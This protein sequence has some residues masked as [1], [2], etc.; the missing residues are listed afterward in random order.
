M[1]RT[2]LAAVAAATML[3]VPVA[4]SAHVPGAGRSNA[5]V[6][7]P[8]VAKNTE[9]LTTVPLGAAIS[10]E[11]AHT[12]SY[13]YVSLANGVA[14][15]DTSNPEAPVIKDFLPQ[16]EFENEAMTYGERPVPA[17]AAHPDGLSRFVL[18]GNDLVNGTI[19]PSRTGLPDGNGTIQRGRLGGGEVIVFDVSNPDDITVAGRSPGS[20]TAEGVVTTSTHT[21]QCTSIA[22]DY[23]YTAGDGEEFS[24]VDLRDL[25]KPVQVKTIRSAAAGKTDVFTGGAGHYWDMDFENKLAWHTGSG[26]AEVFN[27]ADPL[28]PKPLNGTNAEGTQTPYNDFIL[29]NSTRPNG[30]AF[31]TG[32]PPKL[33]SGN[34]LLV[35]EEDYANDGDEV[36]CSNAGTFQ[37]WEIPDLDGGRYAGANPDGATPDQG[38]IRHLDSISAPL[39]SGAALNTPVGAFCSAHWFDYHQ[40][41]IVAQGFYQQGVQLIDVSD[42]TDIK[43]YGYFTGGGTE[44]WDAYFVPAR[45]AGGVAIPGRKT[46]IVYTADATRGVDVLKVTLPDRTIEA[47][48]AGAD[49]TGGGVGAQDGKPGDSG[50]TPPPADTR[51]NGSDGQGT[52]DQPGG[53]TQ[54]GAPAPAP[55]APAPAPAARACRSKRSFTIH[56]RNPRAK[57]L[58]KLVSAR[59]TVDGKRVKVR[60]RHGR[61]TARVHLKGKL[62]K[63]VVVRI[64]AKTTKGR[65]V[66]GK[67]SYRTCVPGKG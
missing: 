58:G 66:R 44:V 12:G 10:G 35:T 3:A 62:K 38:T 57:R 59:V 40:S 14:A 54:G 1:P 46:D 36:L 24:I 9:L 6:P 43:S 50:G 39:E 29:H 4:A 56:L 49:G 45:D 5:L 65:T 31:R 16:A 61:L 11:F 67:R 33:S 53:G 63:R 18:V 26:G 2:W 25:S 47:D 19:D 17:D 28:N 51:P 23:A 22:C 34:V 27:I 64:R 21:L 41:G 52:G 8:G 32:G 20:S 48:T 13:F 60:R 7:T 37:T 15:L 55:A 30:S 42:P